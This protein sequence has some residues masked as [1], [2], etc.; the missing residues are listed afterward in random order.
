MEEIKHKK[1]VLAFDRMLS[2][3]EQVR[4]ECP[5][6]NSQ[7]NDSLRTLTIEELYELS[8]A[9]LDNNDAEICKE[10]GDVLMHVIFYSLIGK[11]KGVFDIVDVLN[12]LSEKLIRRHPHVFN[13]TNGMT[14]E[15]VER[16]WERIKLK[17]GNKSTLSGVPETLPSL[18]K[19]YRLQD[20]AKG[21]GF[22][23]NSK[24]EVWKKVEEEL[25]E[26]HQEEAL[27]DNNDKI[28][29]EFGDVLFSLINY[30]RFIDVNP[31]T[32]LEMT[33][34]KFKK[35]FEFMEL[36]AKESGKPLQNM[37]INEMESLWQQ[38]KSTL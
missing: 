23:W 32:A 5:W 38:A 12:S 7:T 26:L 9:I 20:K 15:E 11:E 21:I 28:T 16:N 13:K 34:R 30:A 8:Q 33:N 19:A 1:E 29:K 6:D 37:N 36:K 2:L 35:R 18:I 31:D 3:M 27:D 22:D 17:E 10:L 4:N 14:A 25:E 24:Y